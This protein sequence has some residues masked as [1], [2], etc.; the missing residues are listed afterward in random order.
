MENVKRESDIFSPPKQIIQN[1]RKGQGSL[2]SYTDSTSRKN[3]TK[4][5]AMMTETTTHTKERIYAER[6]KKMRNML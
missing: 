2:S 4:T 5:K 6:R 1:E 3:G